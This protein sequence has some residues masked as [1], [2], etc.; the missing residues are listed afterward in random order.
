M[1]NN[2]HRFPLC[3]PP[4]DGRYFY[5]RSLY[6]A[7]Y[8]SLKGL[9][10]VNVEASSRIVVFAFC[11]APEREEW[12]ATFKEGPEAPVDARRFAMVIKDLKRLSDRASCAHC[13]AIEYE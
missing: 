10:L 4:P 8:L 2:T 1:M 9:P 5:T 12:V 11:D 6:L 3:A 7:A 13:S